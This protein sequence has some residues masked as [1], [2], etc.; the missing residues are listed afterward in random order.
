MTKG[1]LPNLNQSDITR[2]IYIKNYINGVT[3]IIVLT[4][5]SLYS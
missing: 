3:G 1:P 2:V 5:T 4:V